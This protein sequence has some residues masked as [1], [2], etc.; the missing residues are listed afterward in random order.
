VYDAT[1]HVFFQAAN[2]LATRPGFRGRWREADSA[3]LHML[4][5][6]AAAFF[7][8]YRVDY[9]TGTVVHRIEGEIP[10]NLGN[11][12]IATPFRVHSD[13]LRLGRDSSAHWVFLRVR[14]ASRRVPSSER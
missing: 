11:T 4:L 13:S 10:P 5:A 6:D 2:G 12:E 3:A 9:A 8:T 7:G 1:G 14:R